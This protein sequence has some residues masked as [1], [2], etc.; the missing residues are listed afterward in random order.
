MKLL[1]DLHFEFLRI[2]LVLI[3]ANVLVL[4]I[5]L[6]VLLV[7]SFLVVCSGLQVFLSFGQ[8]LELSLSFLQ[9]LSN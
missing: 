8:V 7:F 9:F 5:L 4:V 1:F 3:L 2:E 6:L